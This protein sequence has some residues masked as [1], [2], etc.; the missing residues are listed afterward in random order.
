M[1]CSGVNTEKNMVVRFNSNVQPKLPAKP[2]VKGSSR[3]RRRT[4]ISRDVVQAA[5]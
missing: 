1:G 3:R 4:W 5:S 2:D